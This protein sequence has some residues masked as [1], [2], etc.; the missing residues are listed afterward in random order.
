MTA[1]P[2]KAVRLTDVGTIAVGKCADL[3]LLDKNLNLTATYIDGQ[4]L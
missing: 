4:S 2:A 1:A 3:L